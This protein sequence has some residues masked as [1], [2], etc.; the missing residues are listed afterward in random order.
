MDSTIYLRQFA[1]AELLLDEREARQVLQFI[2]RRQ[3]VLMGRMPITD[4]VRGLA[5][6]LLVEAVDASYALGF[7]DALVHATASPGAGMKRVLLRFGR[8]AARHWFKHAS[9]QDLLDIRIYEIVRERLEYS[10]GRI[11][12][13][14]AAGVAQWNAPGIA[15]CAMGGSAAL[16]NLG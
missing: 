1:A 3:G 16:R 7:V 14:H 8:K 4:K 6:G 13:M 10:F 9:A 11:L 15:S 5:Q 2:F 12:L